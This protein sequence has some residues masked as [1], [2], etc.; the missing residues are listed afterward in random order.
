MRLTAAIFVRGNR[1][2]VTQ[3]RFVQSLIHIIC[4][5]R[6][7][8]YM[9]WRAASIPRSSHLPAQLIP[10]ARS[11]SP[12]LS[13]LRRRIAVGTNNVGQIRLAEAYAVLER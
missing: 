9:G 3:D 4:I 12:C 1:I 7:T 10:R 2:T 11:V 6:R 8:E 5:I 13:A